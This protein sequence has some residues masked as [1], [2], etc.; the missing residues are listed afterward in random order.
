LPAPYCHRRPDRFPPA[1]V[2]VVEAVVRVRQVDEVTRQGDEEMVE[3]LPP[4]APPQELAEPAQ[5]VAQRARHQRRH[6]PR[7]SRR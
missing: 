4:G 5:A 3:E 7:L 6:P 1:A 2:L